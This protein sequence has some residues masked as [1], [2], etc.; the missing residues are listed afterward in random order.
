MEIPFS[1][2]ALRFLREHA[3]KDPATLM[4]QAHRYPG[5]PVAALVQQLQARQKAA[6]KLPRWVD[7]PNIIF[8]PTLSVEQAS[9]EAT[10][11][12]KASLVS[13]RTLVDLT[14]GFGVDTFFFSRH[15]AQVTYVERSPLLVSIVRHNLHLLGAANVSCHPAEAEAFL[16]ALTSPVDCLYL[17]PARRD[18]AQ[19][20]V[21]LLEDCEPDV[22]RL[23]PLLQQKGRTILLKTSPMLELDQALRSLRQVQG[24]W[25]VAVE[26]EVKEV[27]Y[28]LSP[29]QGSP[30]PEIQAVNLLRE[31]RQVTFSLR[32]S[33]EESMQSHFSDPLD[34]IYEPNAAILKA[35][36]FK[37]VGA[38]FGLGKLH[39]SSHLYTSASLISDFPGRIFR[40]LGRSRYDKKELRRWLPEGKANITVRNFP[41][42]V[43]AIRKK[44]GLKEGGPHYL[45]ATTDQHQRHVLLVCEKVV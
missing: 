16:S 13:G 35:G 43:A 21:H 15:F 32:K 1:E 26:N 22:L 36:G 20:K 7:D 17:D 2:E 27:L 3:D 28:L 6:A 5:L 11:R 34:Y 33:A 44:T 42:S 45:F 18:T 4:L 12:Y 40:C 23:L 30:D 14:G 10:A 31:D 8:P 9:S 25:V 29:A 39:P 41:D 19:Q 24:V 37:S 38:A